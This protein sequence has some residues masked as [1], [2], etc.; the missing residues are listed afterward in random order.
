[1]LADDTYAWFASHG[2][3]SRENGDRFRDM[4]LS[5]GNTKELDAMYR[6]FT[7]HDPEIA[8]ML[9]H[10]GLAGAGKPETGRHPNDR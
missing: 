4:V 3:M 1:M 7:G 10:R 5:R 9:K 8:P 6:D 2:G